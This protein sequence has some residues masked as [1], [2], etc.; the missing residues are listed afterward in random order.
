MDIEKIIADIATADTVALYELKLALD[1]ALGEHARLEPI[2]QTLKSGQRVHYF[3]DK[4]KGLTTGTVVQVQRTQV[5]ILIPNSTSTKMIPVAA[6]KVPSEQGLSPSEAAEKQALAEKLRF[7]I[8]QQVKFHDKQNNA[9]VAQI[10]RLHDKTALLE[11][12]GGERWRVGYDYLIEVAGNR[13]L[14]S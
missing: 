4:K 13:K 12:E 9:H 2:R 8:G 7:S 10:R 6:I 11:E 14:S 5:E 1:K 3:C